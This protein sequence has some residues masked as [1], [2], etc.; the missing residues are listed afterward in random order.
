M[1]RETRKLAAAA[2]AA[3]AAQRGATQAKEAAGYGGGTG[4]RQR[5]KS[6]PICR[7]R[8]HK[9][10]APTDTTTVLPC[11]TNELYNRSRGCSSVL[12]LLFEREQKKKTTTSNN[13]LLRFPRKKK[14][15]RNPS[16]SVVSC[17]TTP[18][19]TADMASP[20]PNKRAGSGGGYNN[21]ESAATTA[22]TTTDGSNIGLSG[23]IDAAALETLQSHQSAL[24]FSQQ[25]QLSPPH[26]SSSLQARSDSF[27][28]GAGA[29]SSSNAGGG[30]N[31][32]NDDNDAG[33]GGR[34]P[35]GQPG[36]YCYSSSPGGGGAAHHRAPQQRSNPIAIVRTGDGG[37]RF[38]TSDS[39]QEEDGDDEYLMDVVDNGSAGFVDRRRGGTGGA[40]SL[41]SRLLRAPRLGSMRPADDDEIRCDDDDGMLPPPMALGGDGGN[42]NAATTAAG[43]GTTTTISGAA[44]FGGPGTFTGPAYGS[45]RDSHLRGRFLD[46]PASYRD[47]RTGDIRRVQNRVRFREGSSDSNDDAHGLLSIAERIIQQKKKH[48][49]QQPSD[50]S[51]DNAGGNDGSKEGTTSSLSAMLES[52]DGNAE[53]AISS[54]LPLPRHETSVLIGPSNNYHDNAVAVA[55]K[56]FY[57]VE[58][59]ESERA[60]MLSMSLT[61]LEV[62]QSISLGA[63]RGTGAQQQQQQ[64][65]Q[66]Q[67]TRQPLRP[68]DVLE[69]LPR[70]PTTGYNV[71]LPR[72]LSDPTPNVRHRYFSPS[73]ADGRSVRGGV[74]SSP[75]SVHRASPPIPPVSMP[76]AA[77]AA[78]TAAAASSISSQATISHFRQLQPQQRQ[79]SAFLMH[80]LTANAAT[81]ANVVGDD[82]ANEDDHATNNPDTEAAFDM[83]I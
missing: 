43:R 7:R 83:D 4:N 5:A 68:L 67:I 47:R 82:F 75:A 41:P 53:S 50:S 11:A 28:A 60:G 61:G 77:A 27:V 76:R 72:S 3:A 14:K 39:D 17:H 32:S 49:S 8:Q 45:L 65:H 36:S 51:S 40:R 59:D 15:K 74:L 81:T 70:D 21:A 29:S 10:P 31:S 19:H 46:G 34:G 79:S 63:G 9:G 25:H 42:G 73:S 38:D 57:E 66:Q 24:L 22:T 26:P 78:A 18:H 52:S 13:L 80:P 33:S 62:L 20:P 35:G 6:E 64:Q 37:D 58:Q 12:Y 54:S 48:G 44:G 69:E 2:K 71:L 55:Q 16:S 30:G 56:P 1:C 23:R